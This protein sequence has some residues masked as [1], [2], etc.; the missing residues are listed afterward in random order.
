VV[1]TIEAVA[2]KAVS[3]ETTPSSTEVVVADVCH[4]SC[5][6][7]AAMSCT[8]TKAADVAAAEATNVAS[9][10]T[11]HM[12]T[13]T[14]AMAATTAA[15]AGLCTGG[16]KA[17]GKHRAC[18]NHHHSFAHVILLWDGWIARHRTWS[19]IGLSQQPEHQGRR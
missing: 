1:G 15:A 4:G 17:T 18:Q 9:A 8:K 10:K 7:A 14:A 6:E 13:T 19:D 3:N 5:A 11:A 12:A 16:Q 2:V